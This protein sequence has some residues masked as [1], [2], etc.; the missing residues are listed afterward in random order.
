MMAKAE[1]VYFLCGE[2]ENKWLAILNRHHKS[3]IC[4]KLFS[5]AHPIACRK[6]DPL[7]PAILLFF[8]VIDKV[9]NLI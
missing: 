5:V 4:Q 1:M 3:A 7:H 9:L 6:G 2:K 8:Q